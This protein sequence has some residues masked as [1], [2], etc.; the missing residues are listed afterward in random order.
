MTVSTTENRER[1]LG[2][3]TNATFSFP[4]Q[5]TAEDQLVVRLTNSTDNQT[6]QGIS[7]GATVIVTLN[8]DYTVNLQ[9]GGE[10]GA[11]VDFSGLWGP[12]ENNLIITIT[13]LLPLT[14]LTDYVENDP[15][16]AETH[17]EALD[18]LTFLAQQL[19]EQIDR[20]LKVDVPENVS[21][22]NLNVSMPESADKNEA[23]VAFDSNGRLTTLPFENTGLGFYTDEMAQDAAWNIVQSGR[24]TTTFYDDNLNSVEIRV[25]L[26]GG[27][28][29]DSFERVE[30]D[31]GDGLAIDSN[32]NA[33]IKDELFP[34][35]YVTMLS[36]Q[37]VSAGGF[38]KVEF[39]D[40]QLERGGTFDFSTNTFSADKAGL[41]V[42]SAYVEMDIDSSGDS[43]PG[44][45]THVLDVA[46]NGVRLYRLDRK[47]TPVGITASVQIGGS[48]PIILDQND[49]ITI[50][51]GTTT[52]T[53]PAT[54]R[55]EDRSTHLTIYR[56]GP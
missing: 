33:L 41:Y 51:V 45:D 8:A 47:I 12:P 44:A 26:G 21:A 24:G 14:Q 54:I 34:F 10:N 17:E 15:F 16:P 49:E 31:A 6:I 40:N 37:S 4:Y 56:A 38:N 19:Q 1:Y 52:T 18:R 39:E 27:L 29:L 36:T 9:N 50:E 42:V 35:V 28:D 48:V 53:N 2:N 11:I 32:T 7:P 22:P 46:V 5:L 23:L 30:V 13:R 43:P 3:G 55:D 25:D 20:A